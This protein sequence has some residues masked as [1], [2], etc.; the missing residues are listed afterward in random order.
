[1]TRPRFLYTRPTRRLRTALWM[2]GCMVVAL[3]IAMVVIAAVDRR[4]EASQRRSNVYIK[5]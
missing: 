1:M 5:T 2:I 3:L 4:R